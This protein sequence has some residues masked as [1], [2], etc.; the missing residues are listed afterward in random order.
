MGISQANNLSGIAGVGE[1][2]LVTGKAGIENDFASTPCLCSRGAS[3]EY[4]SVFKRECSVLSGLLCQRILPDSLQRCG[5]NRQA[6]K[7]VHRPI[8]KN[9]FSVNK[10]RGDGAEYARIV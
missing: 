4:P 1:N 7:V 6:A 5:R 8:R 2:F 10:A 9:C 3:F